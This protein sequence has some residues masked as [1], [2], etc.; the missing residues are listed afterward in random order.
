MYGLPKDILSRGQKTTGGGGGGGPNTTT[1]KNWIPYPTL[2]FI[3]KYCWK[4][5][6][7]IGKTN[8]LQILQGF[9]PDPGVYT[10][11]EPK[12]KK[13]IIYFILDH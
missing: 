2:N 5:K 12:L 6:T 9:F 11:S 8:W 7:N 13:R 3:D 4:F 10:V 1:F